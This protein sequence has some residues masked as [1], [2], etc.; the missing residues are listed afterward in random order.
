MKTQDHIREVDV[1]VVMPCLNEGMTV[2]ACIEKVQGALEKLGMSGEAIV[3]DNGS[4]DASVR[5]S[6]ELG[7]R[8]VH[9][10]IRG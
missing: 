4:T 7:V 5:I 8:V 2:G 10:P 6:E 3:A 1:S 9:Q